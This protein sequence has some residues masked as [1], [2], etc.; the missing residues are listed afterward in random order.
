[1]I[2][3]SWQPQAVAVTS[4]ADAPGG[5]PPQ[6]HGVEPRFSAQKSADGKTIVVRYVNNGAAQTLKLTIKGTAAEL[7]AT[8]RVTTYAN[9]DLAAV[10]TPAEPVKVVPVV[11]T[12]PTS[13]LAKLAVP[14]QSFITVE[15][16]TTATA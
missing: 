12:V 11:T 9:D 8:A 14:K 1:M 13:G 2:Y 6:Y 16:N 15:V 7:A 10:N 5:G 3:D 4:D